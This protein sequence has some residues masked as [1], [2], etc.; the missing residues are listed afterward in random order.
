MG[1]ARANLY[2]KCWAAQDE[3]RK[4]HLSRQ[5]A[6][7]Q[8]LDSPILLE[9]VRMDFNQFHFPRTK[10]VSIGTQSLFEVSFVDK[11]KFVKV[12]IDFSQ[13]TD[14]CRYQHYLVLFFINDATI[15]YYFE[16]IRIGYYFL[17]LLANAI[18]FYFAFSY[19]FNNDFERL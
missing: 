13:E 11:T 16:K 15:W 2:C 3:R 5:I 17:K 12:I 1:V 6:L 4:P 10:I 14:S 9:Y 19:T 7:L 18:I 8:A